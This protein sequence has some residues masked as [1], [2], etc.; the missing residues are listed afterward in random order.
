MKYIKHI[1]IAALCALLFAVACKK[2]AQPEYANATDEAAMELFLTLASGG[3]HEMDLS[4]ATDVATDGTWIAVGRLGGPLLASA[5]DKPAYLCGAK[6]YTVTLESG[7]PS[8]QSE[9]ASVEFSAFSAMEAW[10]KTG[11]GEYFVIDKESNVFVTQ[12]ADISSKKWTKSLSPLQSYGAFVACTD[13]FGIVLSSD[14]TLV[15]INLADGAVMWQDGP[16]VGMPCAAYGNIYWRNQEGKLIGRNARSGISVHSAI[17]GLSDGIRLATDGEIVFAAAGNEVCAFNASTLKTLWQTRLDSDIA[18]VSQANNVLGVF[19][20]AHAAFLDAAS[21][22]QL[23]NSESALLSPPASAPI[24]WN[25]FWYYAGLDGWVYRHSPTE[26]PQ[27]DTVQSI[28]RARLESRLV[29]KPYPGTVAVFLPFVN[30]A[31][32]ENDWAFSVFAYD[33]TGALG[34]PARQRELS[35]KADGEI[36]M[37]LFDADGT[38]IGAN[39]DE[40]GSHAALSLWFEPGKRYYI[41]VGRTNPA[42]TDRAAIVNLSG[43]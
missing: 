2:N 16:A 25:G 32:H 9:P 40:F 43:L 34:G 26:Q 28:I 33:E 15:L 39:S 30:G 7:L 38:E 37:M 6:L 19:G 41:A 29:Q 24:P 17:S 35:V 11:F 20:T 3:D 4:Y 13:G 18:F 1:L 12:A 10:A 27:A 36:V 21:G 31:P 14:G 8:L 23:D 5:Y 42:S 22:M